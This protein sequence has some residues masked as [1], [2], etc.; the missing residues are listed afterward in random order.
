M[1]VILLTQNDPFYLADNIKYLA[2]NLPHGLE[3]V[4]C[5]VFDVAPFGK[6]QSVWSQALDT[7]NR[8]GFRFFIYYSANFIRSKIS[9]SKSVRHVIGQRN[10]PEIHVNGNIN[11]EASHS[12]LAGYEPDLLVS[13]A[14]NQIFKRPLIDIAPKG[15]I[16]LHTALLPKYRGLMPTFWVMRHG[17]EK[18]GVSVFF[19]DEGIDSG[20]IIVQRE[21]EIAEM[22]QR[23]LILKTKKLGMECIIEA[24]EKIRDDSV[25]L[26]DNPAE[27]ATYFSKP[28]KEDVVAF[29]RAGKRFF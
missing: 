4:G 1:R 18:T 22:T 16:N 9:S 20:P 7:F 23:E 27:E 8:F 25:E 12:I 5:A 2:D 13:I 26:I 21:I 14:G 11:S 15:C 6:K 17:E 10:I 24:M 3:I 28:T 19:V 29:Q